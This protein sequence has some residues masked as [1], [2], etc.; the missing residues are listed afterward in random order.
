MAGD[1]LSAVSALIPLVCLFLTGKQ[2]WIDWFEAGREVVVEDFTVWESVTI[3]VPLLVLALA[4]CVGANIA[5]AKTIGIRRRWPL[6]AA[7]VIV[8]T[9]LSLDICF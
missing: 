4:P 7:A 5:L 8:L 2:L 3:F 9:P 1:P 6:S